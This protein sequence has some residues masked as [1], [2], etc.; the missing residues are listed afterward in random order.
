MILQKSLASGNR[1]ISFNAS[2]AL[3]RCFRVIPLAVYLFLHQ[4]VCFSADTEHLIYGYPSQN[5]QLLY[6]SGYVL[7][8]DKQTKNALWTSHRLKSSYLVSHAKRK[9]DFR[10][11]TDIAV[12][13]RAQ[14][15]D[16]RKSGYDMGHL[17]PAQD[18]SRSKKT[19]SESFLLSNM[20]P[21]VGV[22]FNRGIWKELE[23]KIRKWTKSKKE[24]YILTGP[25][26]LDNNGKSTKKY[27]V[28]GVNRIAIP[29]HFYK[30]V[31]AY[32]KNENELDAIAFI[33]PNE[34]NPTSRLPEFIKSIDDVESASG[35]DFFPEL[36]DDIEIS[37]E[38]KK[39]VH[40]W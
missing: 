22:K 18:M 28:L 6:R 23:A 27:K 35:L 30:V 31:L 10:E 9:D 29:T 33:L 19:M 17:V 2:V 24:I 14:L 11:D 13:D 34:Q 3:I 8:Y 7:C 20:A 5:G 40:L 38:S 36:S 4:F 32:S 26:Y 37:L 16:Y 21:Q 12:G 1:V 15:R 39:A 25:L